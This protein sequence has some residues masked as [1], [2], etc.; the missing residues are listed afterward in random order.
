MLP[1]SDGH[2]S[3]HV[4]RAW[5]MTGGTEPDL[6][7]AA[8][9]RRARAAALALLAL[10]GS[11]YIY[12][13]DELGLHEVGDLPDEVLQDPIAFRNREQEKGRDGCR[14]P[15]PWTAHGPSFGF[16]DGPAHLPQPAWFGDHAVES[17]PKAP[18]WTCI[19]R[20]SRPGG[21]CPVRWSGR[22]PPHRSFGSGEAMSSAWSVSTR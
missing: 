14:V 12:Q 10:P 13:G 7:H 1:L 21:A 9:I 22:T 2:G 15:L 19:A 4:A 17:R 16:G 5:L 20:R 18:P 3:Q 11:L 6:D 8:G